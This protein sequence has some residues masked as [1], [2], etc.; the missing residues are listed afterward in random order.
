MSELYIRE[1]LDRIKTS[2]LLSNIGCTAGPQKKTDI[3]KWN[4]IIKGPIKSCYENGIF[5]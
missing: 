4:V 2:P 1:E 3:Y 5:K